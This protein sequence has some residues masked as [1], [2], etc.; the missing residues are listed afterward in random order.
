M[1]VAPVFNWGKQNNLFMNNYVCGFLFG[2]SVC[3]I[4]QFQVPKVVRSDQG[5]S[6]NIVFCTIANKYSHVT[7]V[8]DEENHF[9][10]SQRSKPIKTLQILF[11]LT[12]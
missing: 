9:W 1:S 5:G 10:C 7:F 12:F 4:S 8:S 6:R 11:N 2:T 3:I